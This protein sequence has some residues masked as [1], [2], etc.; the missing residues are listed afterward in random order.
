MSLTN[1]LGLNDINVDFGYNPA[2]MI[3]NASNNFLNQ[4]ASG[5]QNV[6]GGVGQVGNQL[7]NQG[8]QLWDQSKQFFD[9]NSQWYQTQ[10]NQ[11]SG[12]LS[13]Q[14]AQATN[15]QNTALAA[16]GVGGGGLSQVLKNTN[17]KQTGDTLSSAMTNLTNQGAQIGTNIANTGASITGQGGNMLMNQGN[18]LNMVGGIGSGIAD[19]TSQM[20]MFNADQYNQALQ[21]GL[22]SKYNQQA[23]NRSNRGGFFNQI[24]GIA[25][26]KAVMACIPEGTKIDTPEGRVEIQNLK[27]GDEVIG[28]DGEPV[29]LMQ[30]H[31]YNENPDLKRFLRIYFKNGDTINLCDMHRIDGKRSKEY[32]VGEYVNS[33]EIVHI[34]WYKGVE[35][36]YD[37]LTEDK[38]YRIS[39]V[40]VNSMIPEM[41]QLV[42][43]LGSEVI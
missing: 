8:S 3:G 36:S 31:E 23:G 6:A 18:L 39:G 29:T 21:F 7:I 11:I 24:L 37:L 30:K 4:A 13:N 32:N 38:G 15:L 40:P 19:R 33:K 17:L 28:Y 25:G 12:D 14:A 9:P 2:Q 34:K 10:R 42:N 43:F 5:L 22:T 35:T 1:W 26:T 27:S 41:M 16:R 20:N